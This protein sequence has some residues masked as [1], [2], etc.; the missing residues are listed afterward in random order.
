MHG[1]R[2]EEIVP[3]QYKNLNL[4][5]KYIKISDAVYFEHNQPILKSTK[6]EDKR[7]VPIF[8]VLFDT[9]KDMFDTHKKS[10]YIFPNKKQ[11]I[12][13]ATSIRRKFESVIKLIN[14]EIEKENK[15]N[16]TENDNIKFTPHQLR[17][18]YV[19]ILHKAGVDIKQAQIWT[20]HKDVRVLL[21]I[22]THLDSQDNQS[23]VDKVNQFLA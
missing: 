21:D 12:M 23:S 1:L 6:N 7:K 3:L 17:H 13:S 8:N 22:Y 18:T 20:G 10:D 5:E 11:E 4:E 16:N 15:E 19:C 14:K 9:L 2:R